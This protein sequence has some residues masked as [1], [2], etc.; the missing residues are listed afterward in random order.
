MCGTLTARLAD[1]HKDLELAKRYAIQTLRWSSSSIIRFL[2]SFSFTASYYK[3]SNFEGDVMV[4]LLFSGK[5]QLL[6]ESEHLEV[7]FLSYDL[8]RKRST[9]YY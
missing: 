1:R 7:K 9:K 8:T 3:M 5:T 2:S 6:V 4:R